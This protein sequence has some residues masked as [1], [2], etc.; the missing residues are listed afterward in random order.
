MVDEWEEGGQV[1]R[2]GFTSGTLNEHVVKGEVC[3]IFL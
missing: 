1:S 2:F 3:H